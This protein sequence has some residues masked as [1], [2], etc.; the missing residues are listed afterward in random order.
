MAR[1]LELEAYVAGGG[2]RGSSEQNPGKDWEEVGHDDE[3]ESRA[4]N[5]DYCAKEQKQD[6]QHASS[7]AQNRRFV[8]GKSLEFSCS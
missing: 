8:K 7:I 2:E 6:Y 1:E 4:Y 3:S 5:N